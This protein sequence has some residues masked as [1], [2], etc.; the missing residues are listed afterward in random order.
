MA[1]VVAVADG[2]VGIVAAGT[3]AKSWQPMNCLGSHVHLKQYFG[4]ALL[5]LADLPGTNNSW[6]VNSMILRVMIAM[7][8]ME[9]SM[10]KRPVGL[11]GN[12]CCH[13]QTWPTEVLMPK[14]AEPAASTAVTCFGDPFSW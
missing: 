6:Q 14:R 2:T 7:L 5:R 8:M 10:K 9:R 11:S 13:W 3:A 4:K 12:C 1:P